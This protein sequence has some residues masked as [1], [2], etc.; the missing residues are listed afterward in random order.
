MKKN[1]SVEILFCKTNEIS[2]RTYLNRECYNHILALCLLYF[3]LTT[4]P[5]LTAVK[6]TKRCRRRG[7]AQSMIKQVYRIQQLHLLAYF[8]FGTSK[9]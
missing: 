2:Q 1:S 9:K 7:C 8:I 6:A 5:R 3:A 4:I